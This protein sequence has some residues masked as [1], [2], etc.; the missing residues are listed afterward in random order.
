MRQPAPKA[1]K[2]E[3]LPQELAAVDQMNVDE[4]MSR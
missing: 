4:R 3:Q 2:L 1:E